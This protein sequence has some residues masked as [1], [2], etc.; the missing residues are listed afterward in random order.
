LSERNRSA[1]PVIAPAGH[2]TRLIGCHEHLLAQL[3]A[4]NQEELDNGIE[5]HITWEGNRERD[6][7]RLTIPTTVAGRGPIQMRRVDSHTRVS[8]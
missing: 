1:R 2:V 3:L 8:Q 7:S 4:G 5:S 6:Q